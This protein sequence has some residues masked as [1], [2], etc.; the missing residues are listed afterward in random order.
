MVTRLLFIA[1]P[2]LALVAP[3]GF[4]DFRRF[5]FQYRTNHFYRTLPSS[6]NLS[7]GQVQSRILWMVASH[8]LKALFAN[9]IYQPA[10]SSPVGGAGTHAAGF[11]RSV[12][13]ATIQ[14]V[15]RVESA[16]LARHV[17]LGMADAPVLGKGVAAAQQDR[18]VRPDQ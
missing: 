10:Q 9:A 8:L 13:S 6:E 1:I 14:K 2:S 5:V 16:G 15:G 18:T 11:D 4:M 12:E 3:E 7:A 17:A